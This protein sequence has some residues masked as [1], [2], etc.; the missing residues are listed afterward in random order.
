MSTEKSFHEMMETIYELS[1]HISSYESIPR[2]YG[3]DDDLFMVEAHTINLIGDK[4]Q[5]NISELSRLTNKTKGALSQMVDRLI[6]KDM[7]TKTKNPL[8]NRE[9]IIQLTNKGKIVYDFHKELDKVNYRELLKG[10]EQFN[11]EDF[12]K[13]EK[14]SSILLGLMQENTK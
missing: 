11:E 2:K 10:L 7:L 6:K 5:T 13:Y 4:I 1:R 8:D 3:T 9:V 12:I 14:I